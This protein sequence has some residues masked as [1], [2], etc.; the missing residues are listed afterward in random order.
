[1]NQF[2]QDSIVQH[3]QTIDSL[4]GHS[5]WQA[6]VDEEKQYSHFF[7]VH[8]V[9]NID[10]PLV[11][12]QKPMAESVWI[13]IGL[14]VVLLAY[15]VLRRALNV[16][17]TKTVGFLVRIPA[18]NQTTFDKPSLFVHLALFV[19]CFSFFV[20][21]VYASWH[22]IV[23]FNYV[24]PPLS[25]WHIAILLFLF[26]A[27]IFLLEF[28]FSVLF[29]VSQMFEEYLT[30]QLLLFNASNIVLLPFTLFYF[31]DD[32][33]IFLYIGLIVLAIFTVLRWF[34]GILIAYRKT[35]FSLFYIFVYLCSVKI[36]PL[37]LLIKWVF[38]QE[39]SF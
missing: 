32:V 36:I 3:Q 30:D 15:L 25:W 14:W 38:D 5:V 1:M 26:I 9:Q 28:L 12:R 34:R 19:P 22:N 8:Q 27:G 31:Y 18:I 23:L 35:F 39:A 21:F 2:P 29:D 11:K 37:L 24:L 10:L 13:N 20:F 17:F 4:L 7:N 33:N 6:P 16:T